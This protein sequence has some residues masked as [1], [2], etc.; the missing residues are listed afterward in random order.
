MPMPLPC[1]RCSKRLPPD[2][3]FCRRCGLA[4]AARTSSLGVVRPP[5]IPSPSAAWNNASSRRRGKEVVAAKQRRQL[6]SR[7]WVVAL[8]F[9]GM[10][11]AASS[12]IALTARPMV[13]PAS[14]QLSAT[15][16]I[17]GPVASPTPVTIPTMP[18]VPAPIA[19]PAP[20]R[21]PATPSFPGAIAAPA[22]I[23]VP[24]LMPNIPPR[25]STSGVV[26]RNSRVTSPGVNLSSS[27][28]PSSDAVQQDGTPQIITVP[29]NSVPPSV[30]YPID[31]RDR[32]NR[33]WAQPDGDLIRTDRTS[34][35]QK[36]R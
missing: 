15:P 9:V 16:N 7:G 35:E 36:P 26:L 8:V 20:V 34:R 28:V 4:L 14:F 2:A 27:S 31:P 22:P 5:P 12:M 21:I 6:A 24:A 10:G 32:S 33:D 11:V 1:P 3:R 13:F 30:L 18:N 25:A 17:P 19:A 23:R 29:P